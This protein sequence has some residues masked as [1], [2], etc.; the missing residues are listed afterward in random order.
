MTIDEIRTEMALI[1]EQ[2]RTDI[3][4]AREKWKSLKERVERWGDANK[5]PM[6]W[7]EVMLKE[8]TLI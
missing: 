3:E 7:R 4:G 2:K 1:R 6:I 5:L 8:L